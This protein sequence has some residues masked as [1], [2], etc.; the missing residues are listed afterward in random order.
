MFEFIIVLV[1]IGIVWISKQSDNK[2]QFSKK[3]ESGMISK[4]NLP[5]PVIIIIGLVVITLF[6]GT[7]KL[8]IAQFIATSDLGAILDLSTAGVSKWLFAPILLGVI[9]YLALKLDNEIW[10]QIVS[11]FVAVLA[12]LGI[13][14]VFMI[15]MFGE[16]KFDNIV[17]NT[18]TE[19]PCISRAEVIKKKFYKGKQDITICSFNEPLFLFPQY[20]HGLKVTFSPSFTK[21]KG[22]L[23]EGLSVRDFVKLKSPNTF[24][25]STA[26]SY[27]LITTKTTGRYENKKISGFERT[28]LKRATFTIEVY[29]L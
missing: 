11:G 28:G 1:V 18:P 19:R 17:S 22:Y 7:I 25:G 5:K 2:S 6:W 4:T 26:S 12:G 15:S 14:S 21:E 29:K 3:F 9:T 10:A 24:K 23:L 13:L 16:D 8:Q 20:Q 27:K